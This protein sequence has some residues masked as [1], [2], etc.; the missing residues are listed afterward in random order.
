LYTLVPL[1]SES[2][3][4]EFVDTIGIEALSMTEGVYG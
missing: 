3:L 4:S 2:F 1:V